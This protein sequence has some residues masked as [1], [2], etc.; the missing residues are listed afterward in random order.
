MRE[1]VKQGRG[2]LA[3]PNTPVHFGEAQVGGDDEAVVLVEFA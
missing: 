2:H 1:P 3:I